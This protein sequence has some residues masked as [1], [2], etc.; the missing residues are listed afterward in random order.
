MHDMRNKT[1]QFTKASACGNDFLIISAAEDD[2][3]L[4]GI[5]RALCNRHNGVGADGVEWV[6]SDSQADARVRL[7]NADGSE[8]EISGNGTRCVAAEI[9]SRTAKQEVVIRTEAGLKMC[10]LIKREGMA[11]EFE[12]A[13]GSAIVGEQFTVE[14]TGGAGRE[15]VNGVRVSTGNPHFVIL[16]EK[17][18]N[19]WQWQAAAIQKL[20]QFPQGTNVE[21]V[22]VRGTHKSSHEISHE[23]EIRLF[24]RGVGETLSSGTGSCA[25]AVA[26]I[27]SGRVSSPVS[28]AAP[29]G[30]QIV[31]C[32]ETVNLSQVYLCGPAT[33]ICRGEYFL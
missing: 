14:V 4:A 3:N 30:T 13:M 25:A 26:A 10:K 16:G 20:P 8:A 17:F 18:P 7:F 19:D 31:R 33:L 21:Y 2:P 23:I 32:E 27:A 1:I 22:V 29:G 24:E 6:F 5:S 12:S 15:S 28:V 11:F 9:C